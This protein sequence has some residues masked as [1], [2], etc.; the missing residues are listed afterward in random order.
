[1]DTVAG[2]NYH[3]KNENK[4]KRE[5]IYLSA[6]KDL[7]DLKPVKS[8]ALRFNSMQSPLMRLSIDY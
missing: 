3:K 7:D 5:N 2:I 8:P 6:K 1:M 4:K